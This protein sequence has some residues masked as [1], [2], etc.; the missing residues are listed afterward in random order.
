MVHVGFSDE[1][2]SNF[3]FKKLQNGYVVPDISLA[4]L[5]RRHREQIRE[6]VE[7]AVTAERL[8]YDY[9]VHPEHHF[10]L[11]GPLSPNPLVTQTAIAQQTD[12]IRLLQMA[13]ILPWQDPVRLA[14]QTAMLDILS[15]GRAEVGV[16]RGSKG[17]EAATLGQYWGGS[18][19]NE[20]KNRQSFEEKL[21]VLTS[22]WTDDLVSHE[23][24]FHSVPPRHTQ[25]NNDVERLFLD[26]ESDHEPEEYLND[27][28]RTTTLDSL[29]VSPKPQQ[30]PHPQLWK[31]GVSPQSLEWAARRGINVCTFCTMFDNVA[32]R[33]ETYYEAAED[34][35]WPDH[36]P[37]YDGTPFRY[38]WDAD[39]R[40]GVAAIL[41][42]FNTEVATDEAIEHW[43]LGQE[44]QQSLSKATSPPEQAKR[45]DIDADSLIEQYDAPVVGDTDEILDAMAQFTETC[46]YEDLVIIPAFNLAG[47]TRE[48]HE[49]QLQSFAEDVVPY[50]EDER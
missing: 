17:V 19:Q 38:G 40:R 43:K 34:A 28:G 12:D 16:G 36:R 37:D 31:P 48:E 5:Q 10:S 13:N 32:E 30:S 46:D 7:V 9:A 26:G 33:I 50:L 14:E 24:E 18:V 41:E 25:W 1:G 49:V 23:G 8:G 3:S 21:D 22:A 20:E 27:D 39:R 47:M 42:V 45:I 29:F 11:S 44:F 15:D 6:Q 4:E 2:T 35:G